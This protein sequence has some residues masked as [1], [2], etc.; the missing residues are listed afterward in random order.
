VNG[1]QPSQQVIRPNFSIQAMNSSYSLQ[2]VEALDS[3]LFDNMFHLSTATPTTTPLAASFNINGNP[4]QKLI[5]PNLNIQEMTKFSFFYRPCNDNQMYHINCEEMP[6]SFENF[7]QLI[8][9][10][11]NNSIHNHVQFDNI[12][13]FYHVQI[14]SKKIYKLTCEMIPY[15]FMIQFLNKNIYGREFNQ[16]EQQQKFSRHHQENLRLHLKKDLVNYFTPKKIYKQNN[17]LYNNFIQDY[18][19][20]EN[21]I[22]SNTNTF[23]HAQQYNNATTLPHNQSFIS[24]QDNGYHMAV[25]QNHGENY[26]Q[27][28]YNNIFFE[29]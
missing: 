20:Y 12:Y 9:N 13:V 11:D 6:L 24:Q 28:H 2:P 1:K 18:R 8:N 5:N 14:D 23:N 19:A 25:S 3:S 26:N 15:T 17:D 10:V 29:G 7:S 16:I 27:S 22:S 4:L 21:M